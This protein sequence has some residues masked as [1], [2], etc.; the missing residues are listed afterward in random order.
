MKLKTMQ[1]IET[2]TVIGAGTEKDLSRHLYEYWSMEGEKLA[3]F[4]SINEEKGRDG[5]WNRIF[6]R[7]TTPTQ[8]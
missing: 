4:D 8:R 1:V 2:C 6:K 3:E 5:K 7:P